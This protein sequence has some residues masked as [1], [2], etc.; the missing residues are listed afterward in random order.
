MEGQSEPAAVAEKVKY[1][2]GEDEDTL[3]DRFGDRAEEKKEAT[4]SRNSQ[5]FF[6]AL[7]REGMKRPAI[8]QNQSNF[9]SVFTPIEP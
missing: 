6:P 7:A 3:P 4:V 9:A 1:L 2:C 5:I 8:R